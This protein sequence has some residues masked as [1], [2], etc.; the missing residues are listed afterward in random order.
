MRR[1]VSAAVIL[2][3]VGFGCASAPETASAPESG[4][5]LVVEGF[6]F[7]QVPTV[8]S[9]AGF[10]IE[11]R[12]SGRHT[13]TSTDDAWPSLDL[14]AGETVQFTVPSGLAPGTYSFFCQVHPDSMGGRLTV[15]A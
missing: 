10:A 11:N 14:P 4:P 8:A 5:R 9:G 3:I 6:A 12:D 7:G 13:F 1:V 15:E 2:G